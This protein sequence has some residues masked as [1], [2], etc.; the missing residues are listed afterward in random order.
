[1]DE[2]MVTFLTSRVFGDML[3]S[4]Y[5]P[6]FANMNLTLFKSR[7]AYNKLAYVDASAY[8]G[9]LEHKMSNNFNSMLRKIYNDKKFKTLYFDEFKR[10]LTEFSRGN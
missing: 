5:N 10:Y 3:P 8:F 2:G 7:Q 4:A 6:G 1:M 9:Q